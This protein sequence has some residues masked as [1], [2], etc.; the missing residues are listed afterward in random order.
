LL[1]QPSIVVATVQSLG[2]V[3]TIKHFRQG[4][5]RR[6]SKKFMRSMM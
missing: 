5:F 2:V 1:S 4:L 6:L 3:L